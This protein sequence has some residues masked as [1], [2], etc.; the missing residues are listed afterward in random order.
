MLLTPNIFIK[1]LKSLEGD[2]QVPSIALNCLSSI[3][4]EDLA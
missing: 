2:C 4:N 3:C 1:D